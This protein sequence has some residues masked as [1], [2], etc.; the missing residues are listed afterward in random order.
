MDR[1]LLIVGAGGHGQV[2]AEAARA[3]GYE[4]I[5]FLDDSHPAAVGTL[6]ELE[7]F[8]PAYDGVIISIGNNE[9]RQELTVRLENVSARIV[10]LLHPEAYIAPSAVIGEGTVVL[11]KAVIHSNTCIGKG[12]IVGIGALA[13]HDV[14]IG[15]FVHLDAGSICVSGSHVKSLRKVKAGETV[16]K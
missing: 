14:Q 10:T 2:V 15:D 1:S 6:R 16:S 9:R 11:P 3:C 13:D 8:V 4:K 7:R 5:D 12:C